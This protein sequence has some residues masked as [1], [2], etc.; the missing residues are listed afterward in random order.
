MDFHFNLFNHGD[1]GKASLHDPMNMIAEQL[2]ALGHGAGWNDAGFSTRRWTNVLF[3]GFAP[4]SHETDEIYARVAAGAAPE[5]IAPRVPAMVQ[6]RRAR[7]AGARFVIIATEEPTPEGFNHGLDPAMAFRQFIFG[8]AAKLADAV[9]CLVPG[10]E[11]WYGQFGPPAAY[12]DLGWSPGMMRPGASQ[13]TVE[14]GFFGSETKRRKAILRRLSQAAKVNI[15]QVRNFPS[16]ELRDRAMTS[17][18][19]VLQI[20]AHER[21]GLISSSRC[22]T[23]L[24]LGRPVLAEP[25]ELAGPWADI[26]RL[27]PSLAA[28]NLAVRTAHKHWRDMYV[29][30]LARFRE[31]LSPERCVGRVLERTGL[32]QAV[33]A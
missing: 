27:T 10:T 24:F 13:P 25:H 8:E 6:M 26:V 21:M 2:R 5:E 30:Q 16:T 33:A 14:Y 20:R 11:S 7:D 15:L 17:V 32:V 3:E 1:L 23:S 22:C 19:V 4:A 12:L 29:E 18:K 28:F 9:W 31:T